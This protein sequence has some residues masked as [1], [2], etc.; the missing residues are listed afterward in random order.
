MKKINLQK[1][2]SLLPSNLKKF[3][4][5]FHRLTGLTTKSSIII[6]SDNI[7]ANF[8][9]FCNS[10]GEHSQILNS[11]T[12]TFHKLI[13]QILISNRSRNGF[14]ASEKTVECIICSGTHSGWRQEK[15]QRRKVNPKANKNP[16]RRLLIKFGMLEFSWNF[17]N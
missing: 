13:L 5:V 8:R 9:T 6:K 17:F 11:W 16:W 3:W 10:S 4:K 2:L 14:P 15:K 12:R 1:V 7:I